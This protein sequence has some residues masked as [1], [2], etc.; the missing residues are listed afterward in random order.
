[1]SKDKLRVE[2]SPIPPSLAFISKKIHSIEINPKIYASE[3]LVTVAANYFSVAP[4]LSPNKCK[5]Y[6]YGGVGA[7]EEMSTDTV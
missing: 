2:K 3:S 4:V 6:F 7:L 5:K 1:M